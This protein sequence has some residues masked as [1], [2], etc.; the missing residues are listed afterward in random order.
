MVGDDVLIGVSPEDSE[1]ISGM[2]GFQFAGISLTITA[3]SENTAQTGALSD[4]A[5]ETKTKLQNVLS[6][7]YIGTA[8]LLKLDALGQDE[9]LISMG[10]MQTKDRAEKTFSAIMKICDDLFKTQKEKE[11]AIQSI[12]IANNNI[13]NVAQIGSLAEAFP[14]LRN[15]DL[16]GND[17]KGMQGL[18]R[19]KGKLRKLETMFLTG[20]PIETAEPAYNL[21]VLKWFP[22]VQNLNGVQVRTAEQIAEIEAASRPKP[23]PQ[24]GPDFRDTNGIGE[25][26]LLEFFTAFDADRQALLAKY[27]DAK[28]LFSLSVDTNSVR[29]PNAPPPMPWGTYLK[30]SRNLTKITHLPARVQRL[31]VGINSIYG[32][33]KDM[34]QT[35]HPDIKADLSRYIMDCHLLPG[36]VDPSGQNALGLDGMIISVHGQFEEFQQT[37][38][39][40]ATRSFSRTFVLGPGVAGG[41]PIR[42]VSDM[43][44]LRAFNPLPDHFAEV[45]ASVTQTHD[46]QQ[47]PAMIA[48]LSKQTG[49]TAEYSKMCLSESN[50]DFN[51]GLALFHERKVF[52]QSLTHLQATQF[53]TTFGLGPTSSTSIC[54]GNMPVEDNAHSIFMMWEKKEKEKEKGSIAHSAVWCG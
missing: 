40:M 45:P 52:S 10:A 33:W 4:S 3:H 25:N 49:M 36:L 27:Y 47:H 8:K 18:L 28:S 23:I 11:E 13:D 48:E 44:N 50:W 46:T 43:L 30:F 51:K 12:S 37:T 19:W 7:R 17:I 29:D 26:F 34:P 15:I 54:I 24:H 31:F 42:V 1:N 38:G 32:L 21:E 39:K 41:N 9:T 53:L 2:S 16:S 20:N 5:N 6:N 22:K 14:D 35:K